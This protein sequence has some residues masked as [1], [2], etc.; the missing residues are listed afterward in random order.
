[1]AWG[2]PLDIPPSTYPPLSGQYA[3][4]WN[5]FLLPLL[6][7]LGQYP[8]VCITSRPFRQEI[9]GRC[10]SCEGSLDASKFIQRCF[11]ESLFTLILSSLS[12]SNHSSKWPSKPLHIKAALLGNF[13][14]F[15]GVLVCN[16]PRGLYDW[17][18]RRYA[19]AV[20]PNKNLLSVSKMFPWS[21]LTTLIF[22]DAIF[23]RREFTLTY[24]SDW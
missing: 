1:M 23:R 18:T 21:V 9:W 8:H 14:C 11:A 20:P 2:T 10:L 22:S 4:Y 19:Q 17:L 16:V 5:A 7:L 24:L 12:K 6:S 3:S 15:D 13:A